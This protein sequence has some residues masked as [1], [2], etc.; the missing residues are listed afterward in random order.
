MM[1]G[2]QGFTLV[3]LLIAIAITGLIVSFLGVATHQIITVTE[4][5]NDKLLA[6]H[7]LQNTAHWFNLDGQRAV[8]ANADGE[9]LLTISENLSVTYTLSG[10]ELRRTAGGSQMTL[11]QN[12]SSADFSIEDRVITMNIT[13][14]P[15]GRQNV[16]E[17]AI[18]KVYL[19]PTE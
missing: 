15:T 16:S 7:E 19:R 12:I 1:K 14:S 6:A 11:A 8:T 10:T 2:E 4:Y 3:E 13:S 18:Y 9:L 5:G 17:Q